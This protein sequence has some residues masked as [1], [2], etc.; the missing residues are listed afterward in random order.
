MTVPAVQYENDPTTGAVDQTGYWTLTQENSSTCA[1][2]PT[3]T[4]TTGFNPLLLLAAPLAVLGL[5][6]VTEEK[7]GGKNAS[8]RR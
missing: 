1:V 4:P 5:V 6:A 7:K 2:T 3:T 8:R